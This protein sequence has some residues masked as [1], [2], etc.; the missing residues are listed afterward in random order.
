MTNKPRT[1]VS[2]VLDRRA[3]G[4]LDLTKD[5]YLKEKFGITEGTFYKRRKRITPA[6]IASH[7]RPVALIKPEGSKPVGLIAER[8]VV[9]ARKAEG[10][11][12]FGKRYSTNLK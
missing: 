9:I 5:E 12:I 2:P 11:H 6:T 10:H 3:L 4:L 1:P 7:H 8:G